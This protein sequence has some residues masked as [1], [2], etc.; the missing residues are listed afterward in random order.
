MAARPSTPSRTAAQSSAPATSTRASRTPAS[1]RSSAR[2]PTTMIAYTDGP[3]RPRSSRPTCRSSRST[4]GARRPTRPSA[5]PSSTPPLVGT[6]PYQAVEWKT[7]Q[8]VRFVRNPN[9][10]GKQGDRRRGRHPASSRPPT[11]WSRRSRPASSTTRA[12]ST[13]TSSRRSRR[14]PDI[15]TVVGEANGWIAARRSTPTAPG[16]GKTIAGRRAVD[17]GAPRPGVPR[18]AR[19]RHRQQGARRP[20]PRRLRRRRARRSCRRS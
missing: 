15:T 6:G 7:G 1:P 14:D 2:T 13:P 8:F 5:T 10:W 4:S 3:V 19:L 11:R 16:T 18:R 9:Y 12:T 17:E 20:R